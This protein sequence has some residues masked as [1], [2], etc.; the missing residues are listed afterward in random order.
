MNAAEF[1]KRIPGAR[2]GANGRWSGM[3]PA[4]DDTRAS[5]SFGDGTEGVVVKC[6]AGC[7]LARIAQAVGVDVKALF[8]ANGHGHGPTMRATIAATYPYHAEDGRVLFEV[9]RLEPKS[10]YQRRPD[11]RGGWVND[12]EGVRRVVYRLHELAE[13]ERVYLCEGEKDA[14]RL[15]ALGLR[16]TTTPGGANAWRDGYADQIKAAGVMQLVALPDHDPAGA[17][18]A[19]AAAASCLR[20]AMA[21]KVVNLPGLA[22]HGDVSDWLDAGHTLAELTVLV[23]AAPWLEAPPAPVGP[24]VTLTAED[25][26]LTWPDGAAISFA[27]VVEGSRGV[28]A[29]VSVTWQG[30]ELDYGALNLLATRSRDGLVKKLERAVPDVPWSAYLDLACRR[31]VARLREGEP[32]VEVLPRPRD[33]ARVLLNVSA[34]PFFVAGEPTLLYADVG[35]GKGYLAMAGA[36]AMMTGEPIGPFHPTRGG[37]RVLYLDW[38]ASEPEIAGRLYGIGRG[39]DQPIP[40]G[41]F[42]YRKMTRPLADDAAAVRAM[43]ARHAIDVLIV[44]SAGPAARASEPGDLDAVFRLFEMLRVQ[45]ATPWILGHIAKGSRDADRA[46]PYG[47]TFWRALARDLWEVRRSTE[48]DDPAVV[49][50][51]LRH[52][53]RNFGPR[54]REC[55]VRFTF[56]PD[57]AVTVESTDL[58]DTPDLLRHGALPP[59][60]FD[61]LRAEAATSKDLAERL[62]VA[63][64][65]VDRTARRLRKNGALLGLPD[66]RPIQWALP[67]RESEP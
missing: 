64:D 66:T 14:D 56:A 42:W 65:T 25:G 17:G 41:L 58:R 6:H 37:L 16:A 32:V 52:D 59:R 26:A 50:V 4:H 67:A 22:D 24:T 38:E 20:R 40:R 30:A 33:P 9:V 31:M 18:Y 23:D 5:L 34:G 45:A 36:G 44:D 2:R 57:D 7:E 60:I 55:A 1:A 35:T 29:E 3:C 15:V 48:G 11:G 21:V 61:A 19:A 49:T 46:T 28:S 8:Y 63:F 13:A 27:R 12:I 53:K 54:L 43:V 10:F 39:H 51:V 47:S 62:G